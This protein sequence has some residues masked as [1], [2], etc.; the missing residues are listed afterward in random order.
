M[1]AT[2]FSCRD[3]ENLWCTSI[4]DAVEEYLDILVGDWPE[5]VRVVGYERRKAWYD[6]D[7]ILER[8]LE[9]LDDEYGDPGGDAATPTE[10][11]KLAAEE[12]V[13]VVIAG[14]DVWSCEAR[15]NH[16]VNVGEWIAEHRSDW[17]TKKAT[18]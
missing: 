8:I 6:P 5:T 2:L 3:P 14:Y 17:L 12:L 13:A 9:D 4:D 11:M 7:T 15:E 10:A 18:P 16:E 1:S